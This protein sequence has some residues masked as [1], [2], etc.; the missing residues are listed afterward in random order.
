MA[1]QLVIKGNMK[2][3]NEIVAENVQNTSYALP[4]T[5]GTEGQVLQVVGG[6]P[7][8]VNAPSGSDN[9]GIVGPFE[10]EFNHSSPITL[11]TALDGMRITEIVVEITEQFS[12]P[13]ATLI[14]GDSLNTSR[15][16]SADQTDL[17]A[18]IGQTFQVTPTYVYDGTAPVILTL[19][20]A[21]SDAGSFKITLSYMQ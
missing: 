18:A 15:L 10:Y 2:V 14:V 7:T 19:N 4:A 11:M 21:T 6:I 16:L 5:I 9:D 12:D 20:P 13:L 3:S 1:N 17:G 8:W